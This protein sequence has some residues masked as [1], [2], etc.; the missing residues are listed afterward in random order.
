VP[1][2]R[3]EEIFSEIRCEILAVRIW[4]KHL[5]CTLYQCLFG[6]FFM[7]NFHVFRIGLIAL[8]SNQQTV[9]GIFQFFFDDDLI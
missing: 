1:E 7:E 9:K 3:S 5:F 8:K 6:G 2:A 4:H